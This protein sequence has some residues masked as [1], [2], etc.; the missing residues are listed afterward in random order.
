MSKYEKMSAG[1]EPFNIKEVLTQGEELLWSGRP[2][3]SAFIINKTVTMLPI[4]IV[5][6]ALDLSFII[7]IFSAGLFG[8]TWF[9]MIPFFAIHLMPVWIWLGNVLTA[10]KKW[11]R[12]QYAVTD[13]RIIIQTGLWGM[14]YESIFYKDIS[15]VQLRVGLI[16]RLLKV[17]DIYFQIAKGGTQ[18]FLDVE[19]VYELYPRLQKTVMDIQTDIEYPNDLRPLENRGYRTKY[20]G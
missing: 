6:L 5:W 16:D 8:Q 14:N 7:P 2:K 10:K 17:G 15:N 18:S 20:K 4:A 3:K 13:R 12:T 11:D 1:A 19:N 9:F